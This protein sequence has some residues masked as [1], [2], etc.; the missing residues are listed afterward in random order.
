MVLSFGQSW[1]IAALTSFYQ[2][3][4]TVVTFGKRGKFMA[5]KHEAL[6]EFNLAKRN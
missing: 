4:Y 1:F 2:S 5:A 6:G 3:K